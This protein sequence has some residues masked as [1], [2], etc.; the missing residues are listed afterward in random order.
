M[1]VR[2]TTRT[3]DTKGRRT[4]DQTKRYV[5]SAVCVVL[6]ELQATAELASSHR[7]LITSVVLF[8]RLPQLLYQS[9]GGT[10]TAAFLPAS[11]PPPTALTAIPQPAPH[12]PVTAQALAAI[13]HPLIEYSTLAFAAGPQLQAAAAAGF[14][15]YQTAAAASATPTAGFL[16]HSAAA[17]SATFTPIAYGAPGTPV[18]APG[19]QLGHHLAAAHYR[20]LSIQDRM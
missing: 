7:R 19:V 11:A 8:C 20:P 18:S 5:F 3:K 2:L 6:G 16:T 14:D 15:A 12:S 9:A 10:P 4:S 17:A 1:H 13:G